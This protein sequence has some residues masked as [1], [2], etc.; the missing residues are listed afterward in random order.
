MT[1]ALVQNTRPQYPLP[2]DVLPL[3]PP[4]Q[5]STRSVNLAISDIIRIAPELSDMMDTYRD[6]KTLTTVIESQVMTSGQQVWQDEMTIGLYLNPIAHRLLSMTS[7]TTVDHHQSALGEACRLAALCFVIA[8]KRRCNS[9]PGSSS[10]YVPAILN[11]IK[12]EPLTTPN[13]LTLRLWLLALCGLM[14][15]DLT[16][17]QVI[18][19]EIRKTM[20]SAGLDSWHDVMLY[21]KVM[22]WIDSLFGDQTITLGAEV[23]G[24]VGSS[25]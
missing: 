20:L 13:L 10:S 14:T 4:P 6:L 25:S 16:Q 5:P 11:A 17:R 3:L 19:A 9:Y 8:I 7:S 18:I 21:V 24:D 23:T 1:T 15:S 22:P 2:L 12:D